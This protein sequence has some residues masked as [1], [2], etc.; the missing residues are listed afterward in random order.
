MTLCRNYR[1]RDCVG[2][3]GDAD[4][5][6]TMHFDDIGEPPLFWCSFCGPGV[7][8]MNAALEQALKTRPGFAEKLE[9][10]INATEV[11]H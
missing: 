4:E 10:A 2:C 5:R 3:L 8:D 7:H 6:Y 11:K 9:A 1:D